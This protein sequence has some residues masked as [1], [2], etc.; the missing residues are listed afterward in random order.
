MLSWEISEETWNAKKLFH[1]QS[2]Y[3][4]SYPKN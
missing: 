3:G 4:K 1:E 2:E